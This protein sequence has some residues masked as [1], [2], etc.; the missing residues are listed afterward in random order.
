MLKDKKKILNWIE[1]KLFSKPNSI[2]GINIGNSYVKMIELKM[3]SEEFILKNIAYAPLFGE[4]Y[5]DDMSRY[6]RIFSAIAHLIELHGIQSKDVILSIGG[7]DIFERR[8][9][10]PKMTDTELAE[11]VKWDIE[12]YVPYEA[13]TYYYDFAILESN[14]DNE[15]EILPVMLVAA[16]MSVVDENVKMMQELN[17]HIVAI[18]GE[19]FALTRTIRTVENYIVVDIGKENGQVLIFQNNIPIAARNI[20]IFGDSFTEIIQSSLSVDSAEAEMLK[21][22]QQN[23]IQA[24]D[25]ANELLITLAKELQGIVQELS[26]EILRT[27]EYYRVQ[28]KDAVVDN[29]FLTGGGTRINGLEQ[30]LEQ[31][32][33]IPVVRHNPFACLTIND[34]FDSNYI[35]KVSPQFSIAVGLAMRGNV[36]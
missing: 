27:I 1:N 11:A 25:T 26:D 30:Q 2:L 10:F 29:I 24:D 14:M 12:K 36:V 21:Q 3:E 15:T 6:E 9:E 7:R 17:L 18:E 32:I 13:D 20:P 22:S 16:P 19:S 4:K 23:L 34:S 5:N 8:V 28:N 33:S 31:L 35:K